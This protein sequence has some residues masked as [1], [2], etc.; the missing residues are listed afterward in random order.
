MTR[1]PGFVWS[2]ISPGLEIV[3]PTLLI[4][5]DYPWLGAAALAVVLAFSALQSRMWVRSEQE[6][7]RALL[8]Y[9][10]DTTNMGGDPTMVIAALQ[11]RPGD[12]EDD[13]VWPDMPP[14]GAGSRVP[15]G[16]WSHRP[17]RV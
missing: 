11:R 8:S 13:E 4:A 7:H 12:A 6:R 16:S 3:P 15:A 1:P 14:R 9:A 5:L 17:P 10:Q 2:K